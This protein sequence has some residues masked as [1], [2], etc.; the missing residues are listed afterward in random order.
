[1]LLAVVKNDSPLMWPALC[2]TA[3]DRQMFFKNMY[4]YVHSSLRYC[5]F[6]P[7]TRNF[8]VLMTHHITERRGVVVNGGLGS[9]FGREIGYHNCLSCLV[10]SISSYRRMLGWY[11]KYLKMGH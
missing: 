6:F 1:M 10:I 2:T 5:E 9:N 11:L 4:H 3:T 7:I 8:A